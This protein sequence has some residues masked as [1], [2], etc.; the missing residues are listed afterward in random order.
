MRCDNDILGHV[1]CAFCVLFAFSS[2][3]HCPIESVSNPL[4][5]RY[6]FKENRSL[7]L[8]WRDIIKQN[9]SCNKGIFS[10]PE[11]TPANTKRVKK[12]EIKD[13]YKMG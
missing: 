2:W 12:F 6:H 13:V 3:N 1:L 11:N 7:F 4:M 10:R 8:L 9:K 5:C